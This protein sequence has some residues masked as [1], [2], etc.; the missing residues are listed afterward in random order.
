M[1]DVLQFLL[2]TVAFLYIMLL[3]SRLSILEKKIDRSSGL[4]IDQPP[5]K[6]IG[7]GY[8]NQYVGDGYNDEWDE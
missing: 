6:Y 5:L 4:K 7:D 3:Q 2:L 1:A 8:K